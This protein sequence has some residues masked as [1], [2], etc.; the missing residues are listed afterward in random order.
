[1]KSGGFIRMEILMPLFKGLNMVGFL[2]LAV[3]NR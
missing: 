1:M 2:Q 3:R